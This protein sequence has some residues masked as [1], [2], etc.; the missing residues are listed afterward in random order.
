MAGVVLVSRFVFSKK[1][2]SSY[3][4]YI[5]RDEAIRNKAFE[6]YSTYVDDYMDN[7]KKDNSKKQPLQFNVK[8][9]RTS[10]LFTETKDWLSQSEKKV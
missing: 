1:K 6:S 4:N 2:F 5:D 9:D 7:P 3:V 8:S 10:A